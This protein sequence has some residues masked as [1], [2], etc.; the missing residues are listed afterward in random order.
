M[1]L[2]IILGY[3]GLATPLLMGLLRAATRGDRIT[4]VRARNNAWDRAL[5][6]SAPAAR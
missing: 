2:I 1:L 4:S 6:S 5:P 3:L